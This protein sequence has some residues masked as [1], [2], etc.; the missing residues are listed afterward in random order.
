VI[1]YVDPTDLEA[2]ADKGQHVMIAYD[3]PSLIEEWE[4]G[5][6]VF[7]IEVF[8]STKL[9]HG[10]SDSRKAENS[11]G[12]GIGRGTMLIYADSQG[13]PYAMKW[14]LNGPK[15]LHRV[16]GMGRPIVKNI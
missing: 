8:D 15:I 1:A 3:V 11:S 14:R 10:E 12:N 9:P 16:F 5:S 4:D 6:M 2:N 7:S 13:R